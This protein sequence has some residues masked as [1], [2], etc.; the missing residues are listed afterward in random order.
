MGAN[1]VP[2]LSLVYNVTAHYPTMERGAYVQARYRCKNEIG[3]SS[4]SSHSYLLKAGVPS[5]PPRPLY[6]SSSATSIT[7]QIQPSVDSNG[8]PIFAYAIYRDNGDG[9]TE[10]TT[11]VTGYDGTSGTF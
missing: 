4:Y 5:R 11:Q 1:E 6:L 8:A 9:L 3:W 2:N 7:L 10:V